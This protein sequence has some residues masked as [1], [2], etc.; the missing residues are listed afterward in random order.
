MYGLCTGYVRG[1]GGGSLMSK[2]LKKKKCMCTAYAYYS[3]GDFFYFKSIS[4]RHAVGVFMTEPFQDGG[5]LTR[6]G[7]RRGVKGMVVD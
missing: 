6:G 2:K 7:R 4:K 3:S 1:E 5:H